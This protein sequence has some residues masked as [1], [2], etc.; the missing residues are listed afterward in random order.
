[1]ITWAS[2]DHLITFGFPEKW[3]APALDMVLEIKP[4]KMKDY[5]AQNILCM[6]SGFRTS[7]FFDY[8]K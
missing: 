1:M 8:F 6:A 3:G 2:P 5:N 7:G 4:E